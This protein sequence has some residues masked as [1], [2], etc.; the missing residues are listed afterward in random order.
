[1]ELDEQL[2]KTSLESLKSG[3]ENE[4]YQVAPLLKGTIYENDLIE[5]LKICLEINIPVYEKSIKKTR[6]PVAKTG[7]EHHLKEAQAAL[8]AIQSGDTLKYKGI[9]I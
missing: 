8:E 2:I 1:M 9:E 5:A 4:W 7:Y 3:N 6:S